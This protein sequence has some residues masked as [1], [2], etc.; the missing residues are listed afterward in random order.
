MLEPTNIS[1]IPSPLSLSTVP[2]LGGTTDGSNADTLLNLPTPSLAGL[3]DGPLLNPGLA[4][5]TPSEFDAAPEL[6]ISANVVLAAAL[7]EA[8]NTP[9]T[10]PLTEPK[11]EDNL[12]GLTLDQ[13]LVSTAL[14]STLAPQDNTVRTAQNIGVLVGGRAFGGSVSASDP[15]DFFKFQLDANSDINL[16]LAGLTS[17]ADLY[18]ILDTNSNG[19]IDS[20]EILDQSQETGASVDA[21]TFNNLGAGQYYIAVE[22]FSGST[23]YNLYSAA[24]PNGGIHAWQGDLRANAFELSSRHAYTVVSGNGNV[25]FGYG[26][27]DVLDLSF[28]SSNSV[29][30]WNPVTANGGGVIYDPGNGGRAFDALGL[31]SGHQVLM[32][33]LDGIMFRDGFL[34][35]NSGVLPNDPLFGE[36]W[37]LHMMGVHQAWRFTQG[38]SS[39]LMGIADSGLGLSLGGSLHPDID[40]QRT[41]GY[42]NNIDDDFTDSGTSH[43]TAVYG[44]MAAASNNGVG[45][46]GINWRSDVL[47]IDV[48]GNDAYNL[49]TA[50]QLMTDYATST[51]RRL[52]VNMSLGAH[53]P[54]PGAMPALEQL[55]AQNQDNALFVISSG[56]DDDGFNS[57]PATLSQVYGNVMAI[58]ASWGVRDAYGDPTEPGDRISYPGWWGSNYGYGLSLMGPSEVITTAAGLTSSGVGFGYYQNAPAGTPF[59][60]T[61]AAAPNVS[62]VASLVWSANPYLS[63]GQ[64]HSILQQTAVDLGFPGY[65][66]EHGAGMVNADA[67][68][69]RA[70]ALAGTP[71]RSSTAEAQSALALPLLASDA[72]TIALPVDLVTQPTGSDAIALDIVA[73]ATVTPSPVEESRASWD[74]FSRR[75]SRPWINGTQAVTP[76]FGDRPDTSTSLL[77]ETV[78]SQANAISELALSQIA[79]VTFGIEDILG[80]S[81]HQ[82]PWELEALT[83][84]LLAA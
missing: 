75:F 71:L 20:G 56:N 72:L 31:S 18:L 12:L 51:G 48:F 49:D 76:G 26:Y 83:T 62:G 14:D 11:P 40:G 52:V 69:R 78:S 33:G 77:S 57:Y 73:E 64:V 70:M 65:D 23:G 67:A 58:G 60:G 34:N 59:N 10:S 8:A 17:D 29:N 81:Y 66:Y 44:I 24:N 61:S 15:I 80:N 37:N 1:S 21:I 25:D 54:G 41:Y 39:V 42:G 63:A 43:G 46:S 53:G 6:L 50:N 82:A 32:E 28:A 79:E 38:S 45:M 3:A 30:Y 2:S 35:L 19:I 5:T 36:Q 84:N 47:N 13:G 4:V 74:G 27:G 9:T 68:V 16:M 55:I 22:Q 7:A